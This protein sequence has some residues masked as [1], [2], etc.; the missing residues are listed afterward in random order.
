MTTTPQEKKDVKKMATVLK[1]ARHQ[2][3]IPA[4]WYNG[5]YV[6]VRSSALAQYNTPNTSNFANKER[7]VSV[8][9]KCH[10]M[11]H[12]LLRQM[13]DIPPLV[14]NLHHP[15]AHENRYLDRHRVHYSPVLGRSPP[16][17]L[18]QCTTRRRNMARI[19]LQRQTPPLDLL[20]RCPGGLLGGLGHIHLYLA[21]SA[22]CAVA[23]A[24]KTAAAAVCD[25]L[26]GVDVSICLSGTWLIW[27][28]F[29]QCKRR[30]ERKD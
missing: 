23:N 10:D 5:T 19:A 29:L 26:D 8:R 20:G 6:K 11:P 25:I 17:L 7:A 24:A 3:N 14:A 15:R 21:T 30:E 9:L 12:G 22:A 1:F 4:C 2:W 16:I 13:L 27:K 18:F 28:A